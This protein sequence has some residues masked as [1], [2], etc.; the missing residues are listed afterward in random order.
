MIPSFISPMAHIPSIDMGQV[1]NKEKGVFFF[2]VK[3]QVR[4]RETGIFLTAIEV[5]KPM[6][7]RLIK[8]E[9][10]PHLLFKNLVIGGQNQLRGDQVEVPIEKLNKV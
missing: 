6:D 2:K 7:N 10:L 9:I 5:R 3:A 4:F 1:P 8:G